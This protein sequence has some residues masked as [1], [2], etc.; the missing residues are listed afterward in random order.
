MFTSC[1]S[2]FAHPTAW[3]LLWCCSNKGY[4]MGRKSAWAHVCIFFVIN[5]C[6]RSWSETKKCI[7]SQQ[8]LHSPQ[9]IQRLTALG[10]SIK[11]RA[12]VRKQEACRPSANVVRRGR[13]PLEQ[14]D[15]GQREGCHTHDRKISEMERQ[16]QEGRKIGKDRKNLEGGK[17]QDCRELAWREGWEGS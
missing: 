11:F 14:M 4:S 13:A 12:V 17:G 15:G 2:Y 16:S 9:L 10:C 7:F 1:S 5:T 3:S 8:P 6:L